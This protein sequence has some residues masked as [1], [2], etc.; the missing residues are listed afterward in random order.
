MAI[1]VKDI[2]VS[3]EKSKQ[4]IEA[5]LLK[6][7]EAK[8]AEVQEVK[9]EPKEEVLSQVEERYSKEIES[10]DDLVSERESAP[11][12]SEEML[13][14]Y[15]FNQETGRGMSDFIEFNKD[16]DAMGDDEILKKYYTYVEKGL[17]ASDIDLLIND[18]FGLDK[19]ALTESQM[20]K[21]KIEKKRELSRA[22][23]YLNDKKQ[24]Y[25]TPVESTEGRKSQENSQSNELHKQFLKKTE[26]VFGADFKGFDFS[27]GEKNFSYSPGEAQDLRKS[28]SDLNNFISKYLG[29]DGTFNDPVGYHKALSVAMNPEKFAKFFYEKG[30]ADAIET[31][32]KRAKNINMEPRQAPNF[33]QSNGLK[34]RSVGTQSGKGLKI[35]SK[36]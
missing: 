32:A 7:H 12:M 36:K 14:Y 17:D 3:E 2:G 4:E 9:E 1:R 5:K 16:V 30:K 28:Q 33:N 18:K 25:L 22:K 27:I 26:E 10:V 29:S 20:N 23:D 8:N 24:E 21:I 13:A 19:E 31:D 15:K 11:D 34:V 6:D 35:K